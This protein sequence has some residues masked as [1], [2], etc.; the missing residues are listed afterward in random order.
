MEH[1]NYVWMYVPHVLMEPPVTHVLNLTPLEKEV[2]VHALM[3]GGI[4]EPMLNVKNVE[5]VV[6][7]V[8]MT[9]HVLDLLA[10]ILHLPEQVLYAN[11]PL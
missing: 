3:G 1:V 5:M 9:F 4:M 6:W 8:M 10:K 11:V 2:L 7:P